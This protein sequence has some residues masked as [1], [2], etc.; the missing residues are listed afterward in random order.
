[1]NKE[2]KED[3]VK[4]FKRLQILVNLVTVGQVI[5]AGDK[6]IEAAGLNPYAL[7]EG[8]CDR[9]DRIFDW[10]GQSIIERLENAD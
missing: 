6:A 5:D 1:M 10:A 9:K 8:R 7:N 3:I 4:E 2:L